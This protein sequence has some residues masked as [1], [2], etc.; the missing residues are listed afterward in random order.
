MICHDRAFPIYSVVEYPVNNESTNL[1]T[2]EQLILFSVYMKIFLSHSGTRSLHLAKL[3]QEWL[4]NVIQNVEP[5]IS[6]DIK[7]GRLWR[8]EISTALEDTKIGI[9]CLTQTN[10]IEPWI[11][12]EAGALSKTRDANV[13]TFLLDNEPSDISGPL[14]D[15]QHTVF[16][17]DD[18]RKLIGAIND[19]QK[20]VNEK[21]LS[22]QRL[23][24]A[25]EKYW[26]DFEVQ[27]LKIK[28]S[29]EGKIEIK[30]TKRGNEDIL[31]EILDRMR[32]IESVQNSGV[33]KPQFS[34]FPA[35]EQLSSEDRRQ[36][37]A[38]NT[39]L[40][41]LLEERIVKEIGNLELME[42]EGANEGEI[43]KKKADIA[44]L[45]KAY[46]EYVPY[47]SSVMLPQRSG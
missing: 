35:F 12:F 4:P 3:F 42:K 27:A 39:R 25:F 31:E 47:S 5:W 20:F 30:R 32:R 11:L 7:K 45:S 38:T 43:L 46:N 40:V 6:D 21:P 10:L 36:M 16:D 1:Y 29:K 23:D 28:S 44:K 2:F 26:K 41:T 9:I 18:I 34:N 24:T 8:S 15:F 14:S 19:Q 13:S 33:A 22:K 37:I 17:K